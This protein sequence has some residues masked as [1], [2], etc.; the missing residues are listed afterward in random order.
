M[1]LHE[2]VNVY[3]ISRL[4]NLHVGIWSEYDTYQLDLIMMYVAVNNMSK[5]SYSTIAGGWTN[6]A[7][8]M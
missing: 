3:L 1:N 7:P 4:Y 2:Y 5:I 6:K 8:G